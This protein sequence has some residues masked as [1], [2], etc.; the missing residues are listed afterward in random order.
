MRK[1]RRLHVLALASVACVTL[2]AACSS[3][4]SPGSAANATRVQGGTATIALNQNEGVFNYI[5]PLL[6]F[7][8]D[9][10]ANVTYSQYLM[11][12]PLYWFGSPGHVGVNPKESLADPPSVTSSDG[13]TVATIQLKPYRW[14]DGTPLTSR[15]VEFWINLL[16]ADKPQFWGYSPGEF[17]DNLTSN[18][19]KSLGNSRF[20]LTFDH[21]Y[22]PEWLYNQL[23]LI[24]PLPQ[25]AWD[26]ESQGGKVSNYDTTTA[27]ALA[28]DDFLLAQNKD[29][30]I[31]ATNPLWQV[32]DGPWKL[33]SYTPSTFDA[34][35]VRNPKYS[36]PATGSLHAIRILAYSSDTAEFDELLSAT[37]VDYGY[38]PYD[39]AAQV[40]RVKS[41]GYTV[42]AWPA[43]GINYVFLNYSSAQNG[44][45][46][47]QLYIRQ[48]M[49]HLIN[50][51]G[52]ISA[53]L[54]GYAYPTY[55]PV[56]AQPASSFVSA[57]ETHNPYPYNP[58]DATT[59]L[60]DHGWSVKPGGIDTCVRPGSGSNQCGTG[61]AAGAKLSFPFLYAN[62]ST[63]V[64]EEVASLQSSFSSA[65]IKLTPS[66]TTFATAAGE[67]SP[68][69]TKSTCW[70]FA[71]V[72]EAWLFDPGYNEPDGAILFSSNGPSN[73]GGYSSATADS[74]IGQLGSGGI[75]AFYKYENYLSGQLPGLWMPQTDTQISA[76][77]S[78]LQGTFPQDP[79][80]NIY[81]ENWY[82]VK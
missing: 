55:G 35:Y 8:N 72:G 52:Y 38:V 9:T 4:S 14:S 6:N 81:P 2:L 22:S 5:F 40:S 26:K 7:D 23:S 12:R 60:K 82:F 70:Q 27:G 53:F 13:K 18:G 33:T 34:T 77:N 41:D 25:H 39:D 66:G 37:G 1:S 58:A 20:Q 73:L 32:V 76:V 19:F 62:G 29:T 64:D 30:S 42:Q 36:G 15:D 75:S 43:W 71:Y 11:W 78:K 31:Y 51:A 79:L 67:M 69:C 49:Q 10:I 56:P 57:A 80:E 45:I 17:P 68:S 50:Q 47:S 63:G 48:A 59:L 44:P 24:I 46:F 65:G 28:V 3:S 21:P 54:Q 74:L 61:V 16:K